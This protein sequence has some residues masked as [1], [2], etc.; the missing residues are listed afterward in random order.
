MFYATWRTHL[1]LFCLFGFVFFSFYSRSFFLRCVLAYIPLL[2]I[3]CFLLKITYFSHLV[4]YLLCVWVVSTRTQLL[5]FVCW[6]IHLCC[7][8][9]FSFFNSSK[10]SDV[11]ASPS[12]R[13]SQR[14]TEKE[15]PRREI[16]REYVDRRRE[17]NMRKEWEK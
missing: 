6:Y 16:E 7:L 10:R 1:I 3:F 8:H 15:C 14:K 11:R 9:K 2:V 5:F 12:E 13:K 4:D 17:V